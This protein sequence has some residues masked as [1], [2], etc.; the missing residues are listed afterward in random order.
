MY[1]FHLGCQNALYDSGMIPMNAFGHCEPWSMMAEE[2]RVCDGLEL[3][4]QAIGHSLP[5]LIR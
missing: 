3:S 1:H 5:L 4:C 2:H